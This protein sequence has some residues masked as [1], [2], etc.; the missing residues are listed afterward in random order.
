[1]LRTQNKVKVK[2]CFFTSILIF[3]LLSTTILAVGC[4]K[5]ESKG[6]TLTL[7]GSNP[8]TLDP[9]LCGDSSSAQY[10]VEIF[11]GLVTVDKD[12]NVIPDIAESWNLSSDGKI[13]TFHLR[14]D[15][16]FQDGKDIKAND[17]KYSIE[18]ACDP[19][20]NSPVA[21]TYLGDIVGVREKLK[22]EAGEVCGVKVIDDSTLEITID[23]PKAYFLAKLTHPAAF[24]V[25][26]AN[27]ESGSNWTRHPN[28]TGPFKLKEWKEDEK[29]V[30]ERNP[31]YY[32]G[33]AHLKQ[34]KFL[35]KGGIPLNMYE[36]GEIDIVGVGQAN[37]ERVLDLTNPLH[38]DL[39]SN[40]ELSLQYIGFNTS[41]P[42]FD[43]I[44]VRQAFAYAVD[45]DKIVRVVLKGMT[46]K[47][48]GILP[49]D[50]P[51]FNKNFVGIDYNLERAKTLISES[52][53]SSNFPKVII[54]IPGEGVYADPVT[55]AVAYLWDEELGV[56]VEIELIPWADFLNG[57]R[58]KQFQVFL[59]GWIADYPDPENFLDVLFYSQSKENSTAYDNSQVDELLE[60]A[61]VEQ[62]EATRF[63]M[64]QNAEK[65]IINDAP[66]IPLYFGK[67]YVLIKPYVKNYL[68]LP[69]IVPILKDVSIKKE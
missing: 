9:A 10:I 63:E 26:K 8:P 35:F 50:M 28:G 37:I 20:L 23:A 2:Y 14:P 32:R 30:L 3:V 41:K 59:S 51:G 25:D 12:L 42:P 57:L 47:A 40:T 15:A 60:E 27:V 52:K 33:V 56:D 34:V 22:G 54:S 29:L 17:F 58:E 62:N 24:V 55:E 11:S 68:P 48:Q 5:K 6:E 1:M 38:E 7:F 18:R 61:R 44:K 43:D 21:E 53:Y 65:I 16:K 67:N 64:Y 36:K 31:L 39:A 49:P 69:L 4:N 66:V 19:A 13:Y 46:E 45:K